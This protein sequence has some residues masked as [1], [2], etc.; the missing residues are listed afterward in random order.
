M[1]EPAQEPRSGQSLEEQ[2]EQ[3]RSYLRRRQAIRPVDVEELEDHLRGEVT[4]LRGA[5]LSEN[6]AFLVAVKRMGALDAISNEFAREHSERLWKQLVMSS[7]VSVRSGVEAQTEA[8]VVL[9]LVALAALAVKVP[10]LFGLE[11][12]TDRALF[13]NAGFFVLPI[14]TGYFVWKRRLKPRIWTWLGLG[15]GVAFIFANIYPFRPGSDT[16]AL[17]VLH[18]PIALWLLVG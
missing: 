13:R 10:S 9:G 12:G 7:A 15:F 4:A 17:T 6:E 18:L 3:W 16:E 11:W 1:A 5:G 14:L 8:I 2:V